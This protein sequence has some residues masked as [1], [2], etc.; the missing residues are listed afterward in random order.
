MA[1]LDT[2][3]DSISRAISILV[4]DNPPVGYV[5]GHGTKSITDQR[6]GAANFRNLL[7]DMYEVREINLEDGIPSGL[8]TVIVNGVSETLS[9]YE[10]YQLD[11]FV[12]KGRQCVFSGGFVPRNT[13]SAAANDDDGWAVGVCADGH[14][15]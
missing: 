10:L 8:R 1:G 2:A 15:A 7:M 3:E 11:Q 14:G 4:S 6:E 5:T 9:E 13:E 12:M